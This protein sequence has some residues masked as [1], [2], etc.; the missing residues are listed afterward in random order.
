MRGKIDVKTI[1]TLFAAY[2]C[3]ML[4]NFTL[5]Q[6]G[7]RVKSFNLLSFNTLS[8]ETGNPALCNITIKKQASCREGIFYTLGCFVCYQISS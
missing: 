2:V 4:F 5:F 6:P 3:E 1:S 7:Y 8:R